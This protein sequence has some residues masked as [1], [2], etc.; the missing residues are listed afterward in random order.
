MAEEGSDRKKVAGGSV[1]TPETG[2]VDLL[3][4]PEPGSAP[5]E[6]LKTRQNTNPDFL[7]EVHHFVSVQRSL[8][9]STAREALAN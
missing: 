1:H 6:R 2:G 7:K 9:A 4:P 3:A 5:S 8:C